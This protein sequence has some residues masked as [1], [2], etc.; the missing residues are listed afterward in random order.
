MKPA[1]YQHYHQ[2]LIDLKQRIRAAQYEALKTV[3][4]TLINLYWDLGRMIC[5]RQKGDTWGKNIVQRLAL[6]LQLEFP[7]M[8]GFSARNIWRIRDLYLTYHQN[9][10]LPPLVAEISW[11]HNIVILEKCD[12][13]LE[14]EFYIRMTC[15]MGWSKN[16]LIHQIENKT[17]EKTLLNQTNFDRTLPA[18]IRSQ[19][20]LSV[21][22]EYVLDFLDLREA[23]QEKELEKAILGKLDRFLREMGGVFAFVGSQYRLEIEGREFFVDLLLYHRRLQCL[24][25]LELKSGEFQPEYVGKLQFYLAALDDLVKT[26]DENPSIGILLCKSK[27]KTIVEYALRESRK[28]IGVAQYRILTDLPSKLRHQLPG[29]RQIAELLDEL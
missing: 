1:P 10:K 6:D 28:A 7:G 16:V 23:H 4:K 21:R 2:L 5:E 11:S 18:P 25:A 12:N 15:R 19:A 26:Q 8:R 3:N 29:K 9:P 13:D 27:N 22:D 24:V 17:Y 20:K 14:R